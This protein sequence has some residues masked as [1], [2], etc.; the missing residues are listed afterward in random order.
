MKLIHSMALAGIATALILVGCNQATSSDTTPA[1]KAAW[2]LNFDTSTA[3]TG[4]TASAGYLN[5]YATPLTVSVLPKESDAGYTPITFDG[6][7]DGTWVASGL[8]LGTNSL[9]FDLAYDHNSGDT[10]GHVVV[11]FK[12]LTGMD[13]TGRTGLTFTLK[14]LDAPAKSALGLMPHLRYNN[15]GDENAVTFANEQWYFKTDAAYFVVKVPFSSFTKPGYGKQTE[16]TIAALPASTQF[17]QL[18][19][20]FRMHDGSGFATGT[21]YHA[22]LDNVGFY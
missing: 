8:N 13:R 14:F 17:N 1:P 6:T 10:D 16:T 19:F 7:Y 3:T 22:I 12:N 20:D 9:K 18:D 4:I 5:T 11:S 15:A 21:V 2:M